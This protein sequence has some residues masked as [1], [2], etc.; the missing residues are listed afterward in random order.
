LLWRVNGK[1]K[2]ICVSGKA[3]HG[4]DTVASIMKE[5]LEM[6]GNSV[7]ICHYADLVKYICT[8]FFDWNGNKDEY[9]RTLLQ[10]VGTDVIR[11][12]EPDYWVDFIIE[13]LKFFPDTWDYVIIPDTRFPNECQRMKAEFHSVSVRVDRPGFE[14]NLTEEQKKHPSETSLDSYKFDAY[15][16]NKGTIKT[17]E[18]EVIKFLEEKCYEKE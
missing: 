3:Q 7:L 9:G 4:K 18:H 8:K 1:L 12:K 15:I 17:L 11:T 10:Y 16:H 5:Q 2:V 13:V 14:S 6:R